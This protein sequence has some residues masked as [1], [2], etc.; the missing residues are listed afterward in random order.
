[1]ELQEIKGKYVLLDAGIIM[2]L[3]RSS[4]VL[5]EFTRVFISE[6]GCIL[7]TIPS[8]A[9]EFINGA[10]RDNDIRGFKI[11]GERL[12]YS[13]EFLQRLVSQELPIT[14]ERA[15][16]V[17]ILS[18]INSYA[19]CDNSEFNQK[20]MPKPSFVDLTIGAMTF[21]KDLILVTLN[22][23]DF[24]TYLYD[25]L[26]LYSFAENNLVNTIGFYKISES[27]YAKLIQNASNQIKIINDQKSRK[28]KN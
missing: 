11:N 4:L 28:T 20:Q 24:P 1:M 13:L 7:V 15:N 17:K 6:L 27:K 18:I 22:H 23:H 9:I 8:V 19:L 26:A 10:A 25:R 14:N 3:I 12:S 16:C 21:Q 2:M 5:E